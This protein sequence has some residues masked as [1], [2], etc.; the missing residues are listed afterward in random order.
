MKPTI[1][2]IIASQNWIDEVKNS[3]AAMKSLRLWHELMVP[4]SIRARIKVT[5]DS[6]KV[7]YDDVLLVNLAYECS[8]VAIAG[9]PGLQDLFLAAVSA[10]FPAKAWGC[11]S[12]AAELDLAG[13]RPMGSIHG[14]NLDWPD[15]NHL[16]RDS[17]ITRK[18]GGPTPYFTVGFPGQAG[19]LTGSATGRFSV[20]LNMVYT[21]K[22][23]WGQAPVFLLRQV[24]D[25]CKTFEHALRRLC[26]TRLVVGCLFMLV[27]G[28]PKAGVNRMVVIERTPDR[29][30]IRRPKEYWPGNVMAVICTNDYLGIKPKDAG[31]TQTGGELQ[32]TSCSRYKAMEEAV[33]K[34]DDC[35]CDDGLIEIMTRDDVKLSCTIHTVVMNPL[36]QGHKS[37]EPIV[38]LGSN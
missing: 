15:P 18:E 31:V 33:T 34:N 10:G 1:K 19:V 23:G 25:E 28:S 36:F 29:Y 21:D 27:D 17:T 9:L 30:F 37:G 7:P 38:V 11:S 5:A 22:V 12:L 2:D 35:L 32:Q 3:L 13:C 16:L 14:R 24:L 4:A 6:A 26:R 8:M 20:S